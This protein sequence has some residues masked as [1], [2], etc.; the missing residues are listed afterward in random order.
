MTS[1]TCPMS[2]SSQRFGLHVSLYRIA[3]LFV[4]ILVSM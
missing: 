2:V 3:C 4:G 1:E